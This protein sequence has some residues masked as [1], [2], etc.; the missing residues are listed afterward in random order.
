MGIRSVN[1]PVFG[2]EGNAVL[3]LSLFGLPERVSAAEVRRY[4]ARLLTTAKAV[5]ARL[6]GNWPRP[7]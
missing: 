4:A 3:M 6:H 1:V 5:T 2:E 7:G